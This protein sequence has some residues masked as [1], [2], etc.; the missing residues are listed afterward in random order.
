MFKLNSFDLNLFSRGEELSD[1]TIINR[2]NFLR[3]I[4]TVNNDKNSIKHFFRYPANKWINFAK[5]HS[6]IS[7]TPLTS[8][9]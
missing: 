1:Q 2:E 6:S 8:A 4:L 9:V 3:N 7:S 5:T